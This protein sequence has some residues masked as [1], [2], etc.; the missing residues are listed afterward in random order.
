MSI[1]N[2]KAAASTKADAKDIGWFDDE[3]ASAEHRE[4]IAKVLKINDYLLRKHK[5]LERKVFK[6]GIGLD[7]DDNPVVK[8]FN[9]AKVILNT[10][11]SII[12]VHTGYCVSSPV[13]LVGDEAIV[14][15]FNRVYRLGGFN[16]I[17]YLVCQDLY[18]YGDA[19]EYP[20]WD[21]EKKRIVSKVFQNADCFPIYDDNYNYIN[22][23]E[24][25]NENG[26]KKHVIYYP[27]RVDT[28]NDS[29][30]IDS[31]PN[32]TGLP[33]HYSS[34][35]K[36]NYQQFG[37]S[38]VE[39]MVE[40]M[41]KVEELIS[42]IFDGV[43]LFSTNPIG[44]SSGTVVGND[45]NPELPGSVMNVGP[46]E[47]FEWVLGEMDAKT[48]E[49]ELN[50]LNKHFFAVAGIPGEVMG[51]SN[52]SN[53][54]ETSLRMLFTNTD[55]KAK[56]TSF[57]LNDGFRIRFEYIRKLLEKNGKRFTDEQF[58]SLNI[59]FNYNRPV[60]ED[61]IDDLKKQKESGA[62]S[63]KTFI[64]RSP[65]TSDTTLELKRLEEEKIS[66]KTTTESVNEE[67]VVVEDTPLPVQEESKDGE[68]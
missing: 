12:E 15:E 5:V 1:F 6:T 31:K 51:D 68:S 14:E 61:L 42:R 39:D 36:S 13:T 28:Y 62:M 43:T 7:V 48:I 63:V 55:N 17:D 16:K 59:L 67:K 50:E 23:V 56:K 18:K 25:W 44:V 8:S 58:Q 38:I 40:V 27:E 66:A 24:H 57:V 54:S 41:D 60:G 37:D 19:F 11:R 26:I 46:N 9:T 35:D 29:I 49:I 45:I 65:Y 64:E 34:I 33:I 47:K 22:F 30:L 21:D 52:I 10:I 53:V 32:L 4:R 3:I 20:Y 2:R